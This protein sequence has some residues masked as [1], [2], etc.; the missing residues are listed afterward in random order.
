MDITIPEQ[1]LTGCRQQERSA[2]EQLYQLCYEPFMRL[3]LRYANNRDDAADILNKAF[4]NILTRIDQ[5]TG[6]GSFVGW[7]KRILVNAAVDYVRANQRFR[8]HEP[9]EQAHEMPGQS[10]PDSELA[11]HDVLKMLRELPYTTASVFSLYVLEG[12]AHREIADMLGITEANSKWH[13]HHA[14]KLLQ[15][16]LT[17]AVAL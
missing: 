13:L 12:Y 17:E 10:Q 3:C 14:R 15:K 1:I 4:F 7:M 9:V 11:R 8:F 5:Y 6:Q 2:Q 16:Q